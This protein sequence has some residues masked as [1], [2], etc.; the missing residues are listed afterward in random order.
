MHAHEILFAIL[1]PLAVGHANWAAICIP[2]LGK[3][4]SKQTQHGPLN[5]LHRASQGEDDPLHSVQFDHHY[6]ME[7]NPENRGLN[8]LIKEY[9]RSDET[10][11]RHPG[12]HTEFPEDPKSKGVHTGAGQE[13]LRGELMDLIARRLSKMSTKTSRRLV[14]WTVISKG[15]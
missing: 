1:P 14:F 8:Y 2:L 6:S 9:R 5:V 10:R 3:S 11:K 7:D 15:H 13:N 12:F 4:L